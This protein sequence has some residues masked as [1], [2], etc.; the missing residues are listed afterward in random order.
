MSGT[1]SV[2]WVQ[3]VPLRRVSQ[4]HASCPWWGVHGPPDDVD[5]RRTFPPYTTMHTV[6][7]LHASS[8]PLPLVFIVC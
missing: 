7:Q 4:P 2:L 5:T 6:S 8:L 3:D 1:V